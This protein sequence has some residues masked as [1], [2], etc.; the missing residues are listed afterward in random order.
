M[1]SMLIALFIILSGLPVYSLENQVVNRQEVVKGESLYLIAKQQLELIDIQDQTTIFKYALEIAT[2]NNIQNPDF[3]DAGT[4][5]LI[6]K[7]SLN[8]QDEKKNLY[9]TLIDPISKNTEDVQQLGVS[10]EAIKN[11]LDR[12]DKK[13]EKYDDSIHSLNSNNDE[14]RILIETIKNDFLNAPDDRG[15]IEARFTALDQ[16]ISE[17]YKQIESIEAPT[18]NAQI[19]ILFGLLLF[20]L[21]ICVI[22]LVRLIYRESSL[23]KN[24]ITKFE[25]HL[26][27]LDQNAIGLD[28]RLTQML[29][30]AIKASQAFSDV[31]SANQKID[32]SFFIRVCE[33]IHRMRKRITNMPEDTKGINALSNAIKRLEEQLNERG[34]EIINLIGQNFIEGL[35]VTAKFIPNDDFEPGQQVITDIIKPQ[36]T[37]K[38]KVIKTGEVEVSTGD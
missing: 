19:V 29:D 23:N 1:K 31:S 35:T 26:C 24:K 36:I 9:S 8:S 18:S 30:E 4:I 13:I 34:Y 17:A 21:T 15:Q 2:F 25:E 20:I 38:D 14:L 7:P 32:H 27:E 12:L 3:I 11:E 6:P 33:E 5:L 16:K 37:Y 22:V 28:T 10:L